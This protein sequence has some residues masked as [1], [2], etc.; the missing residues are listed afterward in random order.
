M[1]RF[2]KSRSVI[3]LALMMA[4]SRTGVTLD[5]IRDEFAVSRRTAERMR[6]AVI[7][8]FPGGA[9]RETAD[10]NRIKRWTLAA[11]LRGGVD[12]LVSFTAEEAASLEAGAGFL[13]S[14]GMDDAAAAVRGAGLKI[15]AMMR[16]DALRRMEPDAEALAQAEG[17]ALRPG[18]RPVI[19][20][21]VT[22]ALREAV[23]S[24][25]K[26]DLH[27]RARGAR[28]G[29][30]QRVRPYGLLY[31]VRH[32]LIAFNEYEQVMDVRLFALSGVSDVKI[33]DETFER[34][35]DFSLE[36]YAAQ[37]FGVFQEKPFDVV[38]R[39]T[40]EAADDVRQF[41]FHPTQTLDNEPDGSVIVRFHAG[42]ALEMVWHLFTWGDDVEI[43]APA[44]LRA[45]M[46]EHRRW[47]T[48]A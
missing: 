44:R 32:Y 46:D 48:P 20:G 5:E 17:A 25:R 13:A 28:A 33:L 37:S 3:R 29:S 40:P 31:G 39:F 8:L 7:D 30:R 1:S 26:V 19:A 47:R 9:V 42:G 10:E 23:L 45:L 38:L 27:Y 11:G 6:D 36:K 15:R 2:E 24:C 14:H 41:M 4:A 18:P 35:E 43:L 16:P 21:G 34:P 12:S 22:A